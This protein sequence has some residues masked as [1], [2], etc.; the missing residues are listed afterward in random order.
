MVTI[1]DV[2]K[3]ANVSKGT[4]SRV[5]NNV[6]YFSDNTKLKVLTAVEE[7]NYVPNKI[8]KQLSVG[9]SEKIAVMYYYEEGAAIIPLI[10]AIIIEAT[11]KQK[12]VVLYETNFSL[13]YEK[14]YSACC[15]IDFLML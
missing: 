4:V 14:K 5:I 12:E 13:Q 1:N 10:R 3:L 7:L 15:C 8:A 2:A 6:G 9:K 11:K